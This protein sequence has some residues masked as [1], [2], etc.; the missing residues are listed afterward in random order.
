MSTQS[1][2]IDLIDIF[3]ESY[4]KPKVSI[5]LLTLRR[6]SYLLAFCDCAIQNGVEDHVK[7][8]S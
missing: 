3:A 8:G 5:E 6:M 7:H 4:S 2:L 1:S